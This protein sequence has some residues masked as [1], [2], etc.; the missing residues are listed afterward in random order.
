[1]KVCVFLGAEL[2]DPLHVQAAKDLGKALATEGHDVVCGGAKIGLMQVLSDEALK[3]G[4][5]VIGVMSREFSNEI[6]HDGLTELH[7][8]KDMNERIM[9]EVEISDVFIMFPGGVG[10]FDEFFKIWTLNKTK[11]IQKPLM[12]LNIGNIF[13]KFIEQIQVLNEASF[14]PSYALE[15]ITVYADVPSLMK[16]V[17]SGSNNGDSAV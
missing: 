17:F 7:I 14:I 9:K 10:T 5:K 8:A 16:N 13:G 2:G 15:M 11:Q 4:G 1:M 12:I 3:F 6:M